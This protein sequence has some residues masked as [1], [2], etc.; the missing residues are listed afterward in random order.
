MNFWNFS[1]DV[2]ILS[3]LYKIILASASQPEKIRFSFL[4][5]QQK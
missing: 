1:T 2:Y 5:N 3:G 4:N